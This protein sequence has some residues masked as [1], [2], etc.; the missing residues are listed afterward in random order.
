MEAGKLYINGIFSQN[1]VLEIPYFQRAYVWG[2]A[3]WERL[4]EDMEAISINKKPY[5]LG[6][7]ILKQQQ[8]SSSS[9]VGDIRTVIDGQQRLTT[10]CIFFKVLGLKLNN[11]YIS[12]NLFRL[13]MQNNTLA[14]KHNHNDIQ[15][16]DNI[17]N[18]HDLEDL[19][20][21]EDKISKAYTYFKNNI[22]PT[23]LDFQALLTFTTFVGIDVL[24]N[25]DEQQIFETIN[26]LGVSLNAADKLKNFFFFRDENAYNTYWKAVFEKDDETKTYWDNI[27][28]TGRFRRTFI[29]LFFYAYLQIKIQK[30]QATGKVSTEDK[31]EFSKVDN[32]FESYKKFIQNYNIDKTEML[33]EIK[34]YATI[35]AENFDMSI[36]DKTLDSNASIERINELIFGLDNSTLIPY[37]LYVLKEQ[38][39]IQKRNELFEYLE[40]YIMRRIITRETNKNYN[41]LFTDRCI[42]NKILTREQLKELIENQTA[43]DTVNLMPNDDS[44]HWAFA[45]EYFINKIATSILYMLESRIRDNGKHATQILGLGKYSL[46]HMMP[47]KWRNN[48]D[49][50]ATEEEQKKRDE[51][52]LNIGNLT[53]ITQSLNASIRDADWQTKKVGKGKKG[54]LLDYANDIEIAH[55]AL[56]KDGWTENDILERQEWLYQKAISIWKAN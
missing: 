26:S 4:L 25:E 27:I 53:I 55:E 32:L 28:V 19:S 56:A 37:I 41:Q 3:Q 44:V 23:K 24:E 48:W 39:D 8:T 35:F 2:E 49:M 11:Q 17:M 5:F 18:L 34:E 45:H 36:L 33:N 9:M 43:D 42:Q 46:E 52:L 21:K 30:P 38:K 22:D 10:I 14:I 16:F 51:I 47:K 40:S 20:K 15:N 12:D 54:G 13:P 1:R 6:S 29:D 50:P 31:I 7:I